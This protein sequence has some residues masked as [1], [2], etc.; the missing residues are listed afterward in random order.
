[1]LNNSDD[2][3]IR[4]DDNFDDRLC[5]AALERLQPDRICFWRNL[6][7]ILSLIGFLVIME[8]LNQTYEGGDEN[9]DV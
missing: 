1:M 4:S 5:R 7:L 2:E 9:G 3:Q 6:M 8:A